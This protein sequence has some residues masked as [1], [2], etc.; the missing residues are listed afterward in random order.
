MKLS[1]YIRLLIGKVRGT[2]GTGKETRG[3]HRTQQHAFRPTHSEQTTYHATFTSTYMC[4]AS[5]GWRFREDKAGQSSYSKVRIRLYIRM[6]SCQAWARGLIT[7]FS[8]YRD[9]MPLIM[10]Y[11]AGMHAF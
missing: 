3:A 10:Y 2:W 11:I 8:V 6:M 4:R 5:V 7:I 1:A 9:P